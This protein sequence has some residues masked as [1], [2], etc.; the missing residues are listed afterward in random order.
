[1][2]SSVLTIGGMIYKIVVDD[3]LLKRCYRCQ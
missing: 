3:D 2:S 1:M